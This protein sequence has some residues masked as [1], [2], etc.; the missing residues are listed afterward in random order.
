MEQC[1]GWVI[2][3]RHTGE[4][5]VRSADN[6]KCVGASRLS[7]KEYH[8]IDCTGDSTARFIIDQCTQDIEDDSRYNRIFDGAFCGSDP[9]FGYSGFPNI[10]Y[11]IN[12]YELYDNVYLD[13]R[14]VKFQ[15]R[16]GGRSL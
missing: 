11:E 10:G 14:N 16:V 12:T 4:P 3:D 8:T 2:P 15:R 6:I 1:H 7:Y 9:D 5:L 13:G